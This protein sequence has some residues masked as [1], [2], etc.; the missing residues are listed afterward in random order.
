MERKMNAA[1]LD[2]ANAETELRRDRRIIAMLKAEQNKRREDSE[3]WPVAK[4][5]Y[6][7]WVSETGRNPNRCVFTDDRRKAVFAQLNAGRDPGQIR[8]AIKGAA[9]FP[10]VVDAKRTETGPKGA[11]YDDLQTICITKTLERL[12]ALA[13]EEPSNGSLIPSTPVAKPK[14]RSALDEIL[15]GLG[16][17]RCD[18][19][20]DAVHELWHAV[21]PGCRWAYGDELPLT[22]TATGLM[23]CKHRCSPAVLADLI[24]QAASTLPA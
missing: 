15:A 7:F 8:D 17:L 10:Y 24:A 6:D 20:I 22:I 12:A 18:Y 19:R 1:L 9:K 23:H 16:V 5:L 21:C 11:K 2:L 3:Q 4:S 14:F 13:N